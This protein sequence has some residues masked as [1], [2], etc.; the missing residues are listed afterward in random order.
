MQA[1]RLPGLRL[2]LALTVAACGTRTSL[3][4]PLDD[5]ESDSLEGDGGAPPAT[6]TAGPGSV[7]ASGAGGSSPTSTSVGP[8]SSV[9]STAVSSVAASSVASSSTGIPTAIGCADG[10]REA[11]RDVS[12]HPGIAACS[13][14]FRVP[15]LSC[16]VEPTCARQSGNDGS[17]PE[18]EGCNAEDLCE[19]GWHV[20]LSSAE[21][22]DRSP[23]G[24]AGATDAPS[25]SF[26]ATRQSGP[27][28]HVCAT[29]GGNE[30]LE[31]CGADPEISTN[32][33]FGC[34]NVGV[35]PDATCGVLDR[36]SDDV[37]NALPATWSCGGDGY[38]EL[39]N[40]QK[41]EPDGGGVLC[42]RD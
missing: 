30:C 21:V 14:S 26:Y 41:L 3:L 11:F 16:V 34:G 2:A 39:R 22:A 27:G 7:V 38:G 23:D 4:G 15:G 32:D 28:T 5:G 42:C 25:S 1:A 12:T 13:G 18:G 36:T 20:C 40:V 9:G 31:G 35:T 17:I 24:C 19:A 29:C 37:C 10:T 8:G 6:V 33:L